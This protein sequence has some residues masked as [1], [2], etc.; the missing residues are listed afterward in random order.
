MAWIAS[1]GIE[2]SQPP[3][4]LAKGSPRIQPV[5]GGPA[6]VKELTRAARH[7]GVAFRYG[8]SRAAACD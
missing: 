5:G 7:A 2:F 3:Y 4:Y 8:C 1:H 6:L